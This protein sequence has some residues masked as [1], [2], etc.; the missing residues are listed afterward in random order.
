MQIYL[1]PVARPGMMLASLLK[2]AAA[3]AALY[4]MQPNNVPAHLVS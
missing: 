2:L 3:M 4:A 1:A